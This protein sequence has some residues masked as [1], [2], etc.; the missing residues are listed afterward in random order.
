MLAQVLGFIAKHGPF[1]AFLQFGLLVLPRMNFRL[2]RIKAIFQRPMAAPSNKTQGHVIVNGP[3]L[4][5]DQVLSQELSCHLVLRYRS[6][7]GIDAVV[8]PINR[9]GHWS[10]MLSRE[11]SL[12]SS[13]TLRVA[14]Y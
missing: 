12:A 9:I 5:L 6:L 3:G 4:M 10:S 13:T 8:P 14:V 2:R 11:K 1:L 7:F